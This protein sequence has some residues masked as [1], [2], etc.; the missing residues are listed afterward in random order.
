VTGSDDGT[1]RIWDLHAR[2]VNTRRT[3]VGPVHCL[4]QTPD[5]DS[6]ISVGE[7]HAQPCP[8]TARTTASQRRPLMQG[9]C[10]FHL[11]QFLV[12][13]Y[14]TSPSL[15]CSFVYSPCPCSCTLPSADGALVFALS[16]PPRRRLFLHFPLRR[17]G[18]CS[19]TLT[20]W[21][22]RVGVVKGE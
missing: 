16:P 20:F 21:G 2:T 13:F 12:C 4:L 19:C 1:G 11:L 5:G 6:I 10:G 3:H 18:H 17:G 9:F 8:L 7:M 14:S 22:A 15:C